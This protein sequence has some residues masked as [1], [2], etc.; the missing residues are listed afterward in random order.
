ME[1]GAALSALAGLSHDT[2]LALFRLL[3]TA[4]PAGVP[5]G[6]LGERLDLAPATLSFHLKELRHAGLASQRRDGRTIYY[7]ADYTTMNGLIAYLT[8]NCC[9][10][11]SCAPAASP[12]SKPVKRVRPVRKPKSGRR[13]V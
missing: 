3:V 12:G 10:N 8:E 5:A 11:A 4:G 9:Q 6:E 7:A 13:H 1:T 2:R